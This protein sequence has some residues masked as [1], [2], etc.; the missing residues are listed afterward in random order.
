MAPLTKRIVDAA[1]PTG[2]ERFV[3]CSRTPG[4]GLRVYQSGKKIFVAQTRVHGRTRRV[5]IGPFGPFTVEQARETANEVIRVAALGRDPQKEKRQAREAITVSELCDRYME[6]ATASLVLTRYGVPKR[7]ST[8]A[9]DKGR[10]ARHIKPLI[11]SIPARDLDR[12]DVQKMVDLIASGATRGVYKGRPRGKAVVKGGSGAASR[13]AS[14]LGGIFTWAEKRGLVDGRN[15]VRGV[16][17]ARS[18][19]VDRVATA[20]ELRALGTAI[21]LL[22]DSLP[23]AA[24]ALELIALTGLRRQEACQLRWSEVDFAGR[25]LRLSETKTGR[26]VRPLGN[27][28]LDLLRRLSRGTTTWVFENNSGKG[29]A[30]LKKDIAH[31]FNT[32][33]LKDLRSHDLRRTFATVAAD[34]SYSD[35]TVGALIGHAQR[36]VTARHYIRPLD[37]AL[38]EAADRTSK[39]IAADLYGTS[40]AVIELRAAA[41]SS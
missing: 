40:A 35:P 31:I 20:A 12:H 30:D 17:T 13:T 9:V 8:I 41:S 28:A 22:R 26:S 2:K 10:V 33:R 37:A 39:R 29:S 34:E 25:C 36:G 6:A 4:F 14:L 16:E 19:P 23:K 18:R 1:K 15:P 7:G 24:D 21:Q 5:T 27:P 32:A 38:I 3:W 11:G